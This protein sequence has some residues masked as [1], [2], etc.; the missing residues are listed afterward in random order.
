MIVLLKWYS[1]KIGCD[2]VE[3]IV[4]VDASNVTAKLFNV[5]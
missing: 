4:K 2:W 5:H 1:K 3:K